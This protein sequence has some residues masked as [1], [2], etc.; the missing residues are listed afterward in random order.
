MEL[1]FMNSSVELSKIR[2][3]LETRY[4]DV[5]DLGSGG[6]NFLRIC[7]GEHAAVISVDEDGW[8]VELWRADHTQPDEE[9]LFRED[10]INDP[11]EGI[12]RICDWLGPQ[13]TS[14]QKEANS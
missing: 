1:S 3:I 4:A 7:A 8:L 13:T 5:Q 11:D 12:K 10:I 2:R 6:A 14:S 9:I